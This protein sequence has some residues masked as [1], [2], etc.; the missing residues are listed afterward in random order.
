MGTS[1]IAILAAGISATVAVLS[2][3]LSLL[4]YL[5]IRREGRRQLK[6]QVSNGFLTH[7]PNL[8]E[9]MLFVSVANSGRRDATVN[10][11]YII[12]PDG[13]TFVATQPSGT[14]RFPLVLHDGESCQ[15]WL[16]AKDLATGMATAGYR[17][18]VKVRGACRDATGVEYRSKP[19]IINVGDWL[20]L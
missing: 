8:S 10:T 4:N 7:G 3:Y 19:F 12:V 5:H 18:R 16:P 14:N 2:L 9:F 1:T 13:R 20:G 11:P 17:D 6:V 15:I